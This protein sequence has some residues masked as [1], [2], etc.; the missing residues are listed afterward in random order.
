MMIGPLS[1]IFGP[2]GWTQWL[3]ARRRW[4][5]FA[6]FLY[7]IAHLAF[8]VI[9]MGTLDDILGEITE[10]GIWTGWVAMLAMALPGLT[11][12]DAAM[13]AL[14]R[15]WKQLQRFAYPAALFTALH[16]GL[17]V[18]SWGGVLVHFGPLVILNLVRLARLGR[19]QTRK[20]ITA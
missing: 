10:H 2:R 11:S 18:L 15:G 1:D 13:R 17:L 14:R 3:L 7:A 5:G 16:W 20:E 4:F 6:A 19:N 8:Y 9:D 12:T